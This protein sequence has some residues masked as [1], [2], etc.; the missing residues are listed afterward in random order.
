[1]QYLHDFLAAIE[2]WC[3]EPPHELVRNQPNDLIRRT[4]LAKTAAGDVK[5]RP[6]SQQ[7][8]AAMERVPR[9][10]A[11]PFGA[12][13]QDEQLVAQSQV[14]QGQGGGISKPLRP[15]EAREPGNETCGRE[16]GEMSRNPSVFGPDEIFAKD[17]IGTFSDAQVAHVT[18]IRKAIGLPMFDGQ[19]ARRG[20]TRV[21][22]CRRPLTLSGFAVRR[23]LGL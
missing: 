11:W 6:G 2:W 9:L 18:A 23:M 10:K 17:T 4:V 8:I 13:A 15:G 20:L 14:F 5:S 7:I 3:L 19:D 21:W 22:G 1:V 12:P 16:F